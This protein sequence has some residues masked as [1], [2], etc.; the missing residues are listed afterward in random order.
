MNK[1]VDNSSGT[2]PAA[3]SGVALKDWHKPV[4]VRLSITETRGGILC[5]PL[6]DIFAFFGS[7]L[8]LC[9]PP[10]PPPP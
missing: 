4:L 5:D 6:E 1:E 8:D 7:N 10:P 2:A 3:G 9:S